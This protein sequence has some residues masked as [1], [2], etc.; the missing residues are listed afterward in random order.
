MIID[1]SLDRRDGSHYNPKTFYNE[2]ME[3]NSTFDNAFD[4]IL[5]AMDTGED[6]DTKKSLV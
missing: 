1:L 2:V 5:E 6:Y 3:Y 4:Y